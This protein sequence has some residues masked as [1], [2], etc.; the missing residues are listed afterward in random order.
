VPQRPEVGFEPSEIIGSLTAK[1]GIVEY[2]DFECSFCATFAKDTWPALR[3]Q[4]V[5]PGTVLMVFKQFPLQSHSHARQAAISAIC[6]AEQG[7][8]A[9]MHDELFRRQGRPDDLIRQDLAM[10]L[11]LRLG[12]FDE[13]SRTA[14]SIIDQQ[15]AA[16][17]ATGISATPSFVLGRIVNNA[18][19]MEHVLVGMQPVE[20]FREALET[21]MAKTEHI[22]K[23][24]PDH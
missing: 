14:G 11:G 22:G 1:V 12:P 7:R 6:A 20:S 21:L 10:A 4:Y 17:R 3:S 9:E 8:L 24:G 16:A 13:C 2:V 15:I 23:A 18:V 19:R 5:T